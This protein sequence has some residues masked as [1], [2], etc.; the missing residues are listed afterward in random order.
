MIN[1]SLSPPGHGNWG[2]WGALG[3]CSVT[4]GEGVRYKTR[5]CDNPPTNGGLAC[6]YSDGSGDRGASEQ[7]VEKC[8]NGACGAPGKLLYFMMKE[9][10]G[11]LSHLLNRI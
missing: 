4:C 6:L 11:T 5:S 10:F 9:I 3:E 2:A 7:K 8:N 1:L